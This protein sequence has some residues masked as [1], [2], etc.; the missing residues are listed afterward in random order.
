MN[1]TRCNKGK[2][3][4]IHKFEYAINMVLY[5]ICDK[6]KHDIK[7]TAPRERWGYLSNEK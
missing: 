2:M 3:E 4:L 6:C 7:I 5:Y 1:C